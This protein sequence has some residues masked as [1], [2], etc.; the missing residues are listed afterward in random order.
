MRYFSTA[1]Q[2]FYNFFEHCGPYYENRSNRA[3]IILRK[4]QCVFYMFASQN[5]KRHKIGCQIIYRT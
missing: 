2:H 3:K 4:Y 1:G 5:F